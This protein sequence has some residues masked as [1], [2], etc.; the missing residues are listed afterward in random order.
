[1][2]LRLRRL[3]PLLVP[4]VWSRS[5]RA[6]PG[7]FSAAPTV[8]VSDPS[9]SLCSEE[10]SSGPGCHKTGWQKAFSGSC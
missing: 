7:E 4:R 10:L 1:M 9:G 2:Q 5:I 6:L 8:F 3:A